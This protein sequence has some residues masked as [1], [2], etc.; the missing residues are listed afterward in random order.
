MNNNQRG[1]STLFY[2]DK[3]SIDDDYDRQLVYSLPD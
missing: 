3:I 2:H 1:S